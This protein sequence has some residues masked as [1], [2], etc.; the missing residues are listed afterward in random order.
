M[1]TILSLILLVLSIFTSVSLCAQQFSENYELITTRNGLP[2]NIVQTILQDS[3]G[4]LWV[5]T[6]Q[7]LAVH[8]GNSFITYK[9]IFGKVNGDWQ[10]AVDVIYEGTDNNIWLGSRG[11]AISCYDKK[12]QQFTIYCT[13]Y[14]TPFRQIKCIVQ[15]NKSRIWISDVDGRIGILKNGH[16]SICKKVSRPVFF[17]HD[18]GADTLLFA[19]DLGIYF[20]DVTNNIIKPFLID[21]I[22]YTTI[23]SCAISGNYLA[24][25]TGNT[26]F[27]IDI[28]SR[29]IINKIGVKHTARGHV[30]HHVSPAIGSGFYYTDGIT[31]VNYTNTGIEKSSF[32]ISDNSQYNKS[33]IINCLIEDNTGLIW[34]GTNSGLYKINR[35]KYYFKKYSQNNTSRKL[36][37]NYIRAIHANKHN[38]IWVGTKAGYINLLKYDAGIKE[39]VSH[40]SYPLLLTDGR[41]TSEYTTNALI[42]LK[43][44]SMLAAGEKGIFILNRKKKRFEP[45]QKHIFS[46][47]FNMAW[48]LFEDN[49]NIWIGTHSS[50]LYI[51]ERSS[52]KIFQY[53]ISTDKN[54]TNN[55]V[56]NIYKDHRNTIWIGT[57]D[58]LFEIIN[59]NPSE[60]Q[61]RKK[62][63]IDDDNINVWDIKEDVH[64]NLWIGTTGYG[65]FRI[66]D[67]RQHV[68]H[69]NNLPNNMISAI[70]PIA[71]GDV[72]IST[73]EGLYKYSLN[74][75]NYTLYKENDGTISNDYNF[76]CAAADNNGVLFFGS[77]SGMI[78]FLPTSIPSPDITSMPVAITSLTVAGTDYLREYSNKKCIEL[79]WDGNFFNAGFSVLDYKNAQNYLYRYKL[80]G[81]DK[82]WNNPPERQSSISYTNL[83]PGKYQL[84]IQSS[85]DSFKSNMSD[86]TLSVVVI[87]AFWQEPFFYIAILF[88]L[89]IT[90][91]IIVYIRIKR[92]INREKH[93]N[94]INKKI[95]ALELNAL[96]SQM[97]P[98]FIFN[99]INSI[100]HY[101]LHNNE[102]AANDYLSK[103]ARLMRL[104][105]ESSKNKYIQLHAEI[106]MLRLYLSLEKLR[107]EDR[108]E[109]IITQP[110]HIDTN[111]ILIPSML[112]QPFVENSI[113]HG[114]SHT[115]IKGLLKIT[116][117]I[118]SNN[119]NELTLVCVVDDNGI[120][121]QQAAI[122]NAS[123]SFEHVSRG[124]ELINDR[125]KTFNYIN[126]QNITIT[127]LDKIAPDT[128]TTVTITIPISPKI[129]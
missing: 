25:I 77:K 126:D 8:N 37:H 23:I 14:S 90:I 123:K 32:K 12:K 117:S 51:Y 76:K 62:H 128:G 79:K 107:F 89:L 46:S 22:N 10:N 20:Y 127:T 1:K 83:P 80:I 85:K 30:Y 6:F 118:V 38:E 57:N 104:F 91:T 69:H 112:L 66:S 92:I 65:V 119:R 13:S 47:S 41:L 88:I 28:K 121:R 4:F 60:I 106:E 52:G 74:N 61:Y 18:A 24:V 49:D 67:N 103:F 108:F 45:Y 95:A 15:D 56:W 110:Q 116:F 87:P 125:V 93:K 17:M 63:L 33:E 82:K 100:Q 101:I 35:G 115:N 44:G 31:I 96:Q 16:F 86:V 3:K 94:E 58:G 122:I 48:S 105:L 75:N 43:N 111:D 59:T 97:N 54:T 124:M 50:G 2:H 34:T 27:V 109:Y 98:H 78:S 9:R 11:G 113:K 21:N 40:S 120:G 7:G 36:T 55:C 84:Y 72:W 19:N 64:H 42:T 73:V 68:Y 5:G 129:N 26:G 70:M 114:F 53:K 102:I 29:K 81:F 71:N 39:Y 99:T